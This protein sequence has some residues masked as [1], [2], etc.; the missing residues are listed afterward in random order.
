MNT[1]LIVAGVIL[2]TVAVTMLFLRLA[3]ADDA[4]EAERLAAA[5]RWVYQARHD[6]RIPRQFPTPLP[7]DPFSW[8]A[9]EDIVAAEHERLATSGELRKIY[10]RPMPHL[11]ETGELRTLAEDGDLDALLEINQAWETDNL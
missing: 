5:E 6:A 1:N 2:V 3:E 11:S 8:A 9:T 10:E 7:L 4:G